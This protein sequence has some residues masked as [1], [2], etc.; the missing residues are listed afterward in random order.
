VHIRVTGA[1]SIKKADFTP[2][3]YEKVYTRRAKKGSR[4]MI[5]RKGRC[6]LAQHHKLKKPKKPMKK[7]TAKTNGT[8]GS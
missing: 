4:Y 3:H 7:I 5:F 8:F 2:V 1:G 6:R